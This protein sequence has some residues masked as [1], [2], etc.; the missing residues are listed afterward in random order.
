MFVAT[1]TT[2]FFVAFEYIS[3]RRRHVYPR[4]DT[5]GIREYMHRWIEHGGRVAIW[6]RDISWADNG[7]TKDLLT[8]KAKRKELILCMPELNGLAEELSAAGAE[9][10]TYGADVLEL[11]AARFTIRDYGRDGSS[12]AVGRTRGDTHVIEEFDSGSH[13]VFFI[14]QDLV[15]VARSVGAKK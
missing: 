2:I 6:T 15:E 1:L 5:V 3:E 9:V 4:S 14:A 8:Q 10:C 12:V 13:P 11:P 7:A